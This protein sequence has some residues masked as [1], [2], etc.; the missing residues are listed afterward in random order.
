MWY[1]TFY[2][3]KGLYE[4]L[5]DNNCLLEFT[6]N[7]LSSGETVLYTIC[8]LGS[9]FN[10]EDTPE[11]DDYWLDLD[12]ILDYYELPESDFTEEWLVDYNKILEIYG[13]F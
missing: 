5:E 7:I 13:G 1:P 3:S 4:L 10:W 9:A 12:Y 2:I 11:G 8:Y 6:Y